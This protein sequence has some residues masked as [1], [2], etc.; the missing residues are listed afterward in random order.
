MARLIRHWRCHHCLFGVPC[1]K[2]TLSLVRF[3]N[4]TLDRSSLSCLRSPSVGNC[5]TLF[6]NVHFINNTS[7]NDVHSPTNF[8]TLES[9]NSS[10]DLISSTCLRHRFW[11]ACRSLLRPL[12]AFSVTS[13]TDSD[14]QSMFKSLSS[15]PSAMGLFWLICASALY[16]ISPCV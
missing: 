5:L 1:S 14:E 15:T 13:W 4:N 16:I 12:C 11:H 2:Q 9:K 8:R 10:C 3:V 6:V 7:S